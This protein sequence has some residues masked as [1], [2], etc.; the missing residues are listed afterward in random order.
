MADFSDIE[1][2]TLVQHVFHGRQGQKRISWIKIAKQMKSCKQPSQLKLRL[3]CL[4][5]RFGKEL[6]KFPRWYFTNM[7]TQQ[8]T[9]KK[10]QQEVPSS[11]ATEKNPDVSL[12]ALFDQ[13]PDSDEDASTP[14]L[15]FNWVPKS[16]L[17]ASSIPP[18]C[19][20]KLRK[21]VKNLLFPLPTPPLST[22]DSYV[23]VKEVFSSVLRADVRQS[24]GRLEFNVGELEPEGTTTVIEACALTSNDVFVD[25]GSGVGNVVA[26]VALET[27]VRTALGVE[28]RA[29]LARQG[30][31][32]MEQNYDHYPQLS[33]VEI[34]PQDICAVDVENDYQFKKVTVLFCHNT[35]FKPEVHLMLEQI[36][37]RLPLLRTVIL[38]V[39]FCA[40]HRPSC[41]R[42]FCT[43]F[44]VRESPIRVSVTFTHSL[45]NFFVYDRCGKQ[46]EEFDI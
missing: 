5:K 43:V 3:A 22:Q 37:C 45:S 28:I 26:Q 31:N 10:T 30:R 25:V 12:V 9:F 14:S 1:D 21:R 2:R 35:V 42:E 23:A 20:K 8:E 13:F 27:N 17:T 16:P 39:P 41:L 44:R 4:K 19:M 38:S 6:I 36:C 18:V 7:P 34:Y 11:S 46:N 24:S 29:E 33:K 32:L 15:A 40:R